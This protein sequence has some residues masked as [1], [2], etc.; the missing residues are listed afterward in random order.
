MKENQKFYNRMTRGFN[1]C[2]LFYEKFLEQVKLVL[3]TL[4]VFRYVFQSKEMPI[5]IAK[6]YFFPDFFRDRVMNIKNVTKQSM[7]TI[8]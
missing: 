5:I 1:E 2:L 7:L 6:K 4:N 8:G 3:I